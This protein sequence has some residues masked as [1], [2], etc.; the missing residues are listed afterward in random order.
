VR[1]AL[2]VL[3]AFTIAAETDPAYAVLEKAYAELRARNYEPAIA[4]FRQA[5]VLA[6]AR[7]DINKE[8]AYTLL[9]IGRT[10]E[11]REAF[12]EAV[13]LNP[14]DH[15]GALEYAFLCH[16]TGQT[17]I[18]RLVFDRV[19][20]SGDEASRATAE[21]A[22]Q[23]I[24]GPLAEGI[25]RWREAAARE[26]NNFSAHQELARLAERRS[27]WPLAAA[28]YQAAWRLKPEEREL[29]LRLA[30]AWR[31]LGRAEDSRAALVAASR[32]GSPRVAEKARRMFGERYPYV[33]EFRQAIQLD[34]SNIELRKELGHLLLTM[35]QKEEGE[36]ELEGISSRS[37]SQR[38][39]DA[40][41]MAERSYQL[42]YLEDALRYYKIA[43]EDDPL[44]FHVML[45]LGFT[46][47]MLKQDKE[48]V[49][50]FRLARHSPDPMIAAEAQRAYSNLEP[51]KVRTTAWMLP[52]YSSRWKDVFTYG[53][54][55]TEFAQGPLPVRPYLS[56]RFIGDARG[57]VRQPFPQYL[58]EKA[59]IFGAGL[60][61]D[62][63]RGLMGWAE[64][65]QA[66]GYQRRGTEPDYRGGVSYSRGFGRLMGSEKPG[67][68]FENHEDAVYVSRFDSSVL[69]YTQNKA[70]YTLAPVGALRLQLYWNV[71]LTAS[72][73]QQYWANFAEAGPGLRVR[74]PALPE[75]MV[76]SVDLLRGAHT[77]NQGNPRGPNYYDFR[78]GFWY[79]ITR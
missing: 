52:F 70:G 6:P 25:A 47:N 36:K 75:A 34:P 2:L 51:K 30:E 40:R 67:A 54:V 56:L 5:A 65:G 15:H 17:R 18:A 7:A 78:A 9:K 53:Q 61:T 69:F 33:Y 21:Q 68:F 72:A 66:V 19:R 35:G 23:N 58:S 12:S 38:P 79:A 59:F 3:L 1:P 62:S 20:R 24:D 44:D 37:R 39:A 48:A 45:K 64:A 71:N 77:A 41:E 22:F 29:L 16:E 32:G 14:A 74:W 50:W 8:L 28:H 46:H 60:R 63:Y 43:H 10:E 27:E 26:P 4:L 76:F 73:K 49:N 11:A 55:K 13:R 31:E 42:G 57:Q